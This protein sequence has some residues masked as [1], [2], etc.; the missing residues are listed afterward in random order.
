MGF[1]A[2]QQ[3]F[4]ISTDYP[5][6]EVLV[7]IQ[8][9]DFTQCAAQTGKNFGDE[10]VTDATTGRL[11]GQLIIVDTLGLDILTKPG[12]V[13][14]DFVV[15]QPANTNTSI[16]S[17]NGAR[18]FLEEDSTATSPFS[19]VRKVIVARIPMRVIAPGDSTRSPVVVDKNNSVS[20]NNTG[21]TDT[22]TD[23]SNAKNV[24]TTSINPLAQTF[25]IDSK[26][27]KN[28]IFCTSVELFF[29]A[30]STKGTDVRIELR[31]VIDGLPSNRVVDGTNVFLGPDSINVSTTSPYSSTKFKFQYPVYLFPDKEYALCIKAPDENYGIYVSRIGELIA[32]DS[33]NTLAN[34]QPNVGK[35]F[36]MTNTGAQVE[37]KGASLLFKINKAIFETGTKSFVK[38]TAA[39][40]P[41]RFTYQAAAVQVSSK[42]FG[43]DTSITAELQTKNAGGT[44]LAYETI[45]VGSIK[46]LNSVRSVLNEGD[47]KVKFTLVNKDKHISPAL[48]MSSLTFATAKYEID[49]LNDQTLVRNTEKIYYNG[50][51]KS[52]YLSKVVTLNPDFDSTGLEV[53][54]DI[55]RKNNTDIDVFCRVKS[56][57]DNALDSKI[58][59][60]NWTYM[61][62][63]SSANS[64]STSGV[65]YSVIS[66]A[67][68]TVG[69]DDNAFI[70]ETYRILETDAANLAYTANVGGVD[71]YFNTFNQFQIKIVM[72]GDNEVG[73]TPKVKNLFATAVL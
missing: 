16:Q 4:I 52:K 13:Y 26:N 24:L 10:L 15:R 28:G 59:N 38:Q 47:A 1:P 60:R 17:R 22:T 55:N 29:Y 37:D 20:I 23:V 51:G 11:S 54:L 71:T 34:K 36:K 61:P 50:V 8:G 44:L 48:N 7:E 30:K 65:S 58:E 25:V 68:A 3:E 64:K 73:Y 42:S 69:T 43:D 21:L 70:S 5:G 40:S 2:I 31:E 63:Y 53:S 72:Y 39:T 49:S 41:A 35:L 46:R 9:I 18:I 67:K 33:P 66:P 12:T 56:S 57:F 19:S 32:I 45:P 6:Q 14:I 27:F 62:L